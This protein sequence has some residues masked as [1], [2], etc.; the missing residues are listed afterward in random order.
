MP[1]C[2]VSEA[3]FCEYLPLKYPSSLLSAQCL[4]SRTRAACEGR[5]LLA[6]EGLKVFYFKEWTKSKEKLESTSIGMC[7]QSAIFV[8]GYRRKVL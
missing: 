7:Y 5:V 8:P 4:F 6:A 1:A 2:G 3:T